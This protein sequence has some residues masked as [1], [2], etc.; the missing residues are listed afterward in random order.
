MDTKLKRNLKGH[1]SNEQLVAQGLGHS[2]RTIRKMMIKEYGKKFTKSELGE[3]KKM[4]IESMVIA[5]EFKLGLTCT[6]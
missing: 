2:S 4:S 1:L 6:K 3:F 5:V